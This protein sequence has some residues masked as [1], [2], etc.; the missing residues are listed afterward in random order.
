MATL[1]EIQD[2]M[3]TQIRTALADVTDVDVQVEPRMV[4]NPTPPCID[5]YPGDP[6]MDQDLA[7]MND[8]VGGELITVR[9]RVTTADSDAGQDLLLA[10]MDD[11]DALSILLALNEDLTLNGLAATL[12][13]RSRSGYT[14]FPDPG[15]EGALL[16]CL[17]GV[18]VVKAKS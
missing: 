16:G 5:V 6:S 3:A 13:V 8:L 18:V 9:A 15:G 12:D 1:A 10:L 11:E 2:E 7:A 4:L 14:L 17:W